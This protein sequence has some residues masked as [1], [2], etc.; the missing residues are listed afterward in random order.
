MVAVACNLRA[1]CAHA[2]RI[3]GGLN[4]ASIPLRLELSKIRQSDVRTR[5][6]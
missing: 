5:E 1:S 3:Q 6:G 2:E 4:A